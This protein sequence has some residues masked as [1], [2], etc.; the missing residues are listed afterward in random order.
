[1]AS[2][3][4]RFLDPDWRER[5]LAEVRVGIPPHRAAEYLGTSRR[6]LFDWFRRGGHPSHDGHP[7]L[8]GPE[9]PKNAEFVEFVREVLEAQASCTMV[10][11]KALYLRATQDADYAL[12]W[13]KARHPEEYAGIQKEQ[14]QTT[15]IAENG[16]TVIASRDDLREIFGGAKEYDNDRHQDSGSDPQQPQGSRNY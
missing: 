14:P 8:G 10:P 9:D 11:E 15:V 3:Q 1:M 13:L 5:F 12:K 4:P 2:E 16:P 7:R 6:T